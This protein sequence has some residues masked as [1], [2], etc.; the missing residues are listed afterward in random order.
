MIRGLYTAAAGMMT[1]QKRQDLLT[2]NLSNINTPGYKADQAAMRAFP[3]MLIQAM[4]TANG[5][6]KSIGKLHQGVFVEENIP[7]F[8]Q[9]DIMDTGVKQHLAIQNQPKLFFTVQG[10]DEEILYTRSG[11]FTE[12]TAGQLVTPQGQ[13]V[14]GLDSK[15][16]PVPIT[17]N[18]R[19]FTVDDKGFLT[20]ADGET[21]KLALTKID[22]PYKLLKQG[23]QTY[24]LDGENNQIEYV[25]DTDTYS[26]AQGKLERSNVDPSQT[27][28][29]MMTALRSYEANQKMIQSLDRTLEKAVN[30][31]GRV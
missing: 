14:L 9:G 22:D 23:G 13:L 29:D 6:T 10:K 26:I 18:G 17:P 2:N 28:V 31:V 15:Q 25:S 30:E 24:R 11:A 7:I 27:M 12:D 20:Y 5:K 1:Q 3:E 16:K 4:D 21:I 19:T 8:K